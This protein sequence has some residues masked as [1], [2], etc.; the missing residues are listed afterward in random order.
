MT[1]LSTFLLAKL[2][3][4]SHPSKKNVAPMLKNVHRGDLLPIGKQCYFTVA[5]ISRSLAPT[6]ISCP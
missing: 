4:N 1:N 5:L 2:R 3:N 6:A